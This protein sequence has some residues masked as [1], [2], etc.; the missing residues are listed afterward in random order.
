MNFTLQLKAKAPDFSLKGTDNQVYSLSDFTKK[1]ALV[2][3][4]TCNHCPY[5]KNS[6]EYTRKIADQFIP[7]NIGFIGIN[8]NSSNTKEEDS[9]DHM[10]TRMK[11]LSFPWIYLHDSTQKT[12]TDYGALR[13]PHFFL[14]D[15]D[16]SLIYTGRGFDNPLHTDQATTH[17]LLDALEEF[18]AGKSISYPITNPI[19][20]NIKWEGKPKYWMPEEACD[21]IPKRS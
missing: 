10:V 5:V 4:F 3:F 8:S 18:L 19:G 9:F 7:Q 15:K 11:K 16:R 17:E 1:D 20:C 21:L 2:V 14:F 13:T 12:A 6:D